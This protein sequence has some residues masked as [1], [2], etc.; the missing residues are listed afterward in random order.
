[1]LLK[2]WWTVA[3]HL[4]ERCWKAHESPVRRLKWS[5]LFGRSSR[6]KRKRT[7][8]QDWE[9][10][11][12]WDVLFKGQSWTWLRCCG[13]CSSY[14]IMVLPW[15]APDSIFNVWWPQIE[16]GPLFP[17]QLTPFQFGMF[18]QSDVVEIIRQNATLTKA[19]FCRVSRRRFT[20]E[21][22]RV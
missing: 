9:P 19:I 1:M 17:L 2:I 7:W 18:K 3:E 22:T 6:K 5:G 15:I 10:T 21:T 4:P 8:K 16:D 11:R 20:E 13:G 12:F 14:V